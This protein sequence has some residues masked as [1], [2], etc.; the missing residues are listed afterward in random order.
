MFINLVLFCISGNFGRRPLKGLAVDLYPAALEVLG[1]NVT[2]S[3][4]FP[5]NFTR[6]SVN[7]TLNVFVCDN[8]TGKKLFK[9][10]VPLDGRK[11]SVILPCEIFDHPVTYRFKYRISNSD[12]GG[13][14]SQTL[15]L[16]WGGIHIDSPTNHTA[17]T[18]FNSIRIRH[19]RKCLPKSYRDEVNLYYIKGDSKVFVTRKFIRKLSSGKQRIPKMPQ[20]RMGFTCDVFDTQGI[21]YFEYRT[22]YA[23]LTLAKSEAI[24]VYWSQQTLSSPVSTIFPCTNS[25]PI[26]FEQPSCS[27]V[28]SQDALVLGDRYSEKPI[29]QKPVQQGHNVAFFQCSLFND[30]VEEYC[31]HYI[32][33]SR[34]TKST[35]IVASLC[36]PSHPPGTYSG[37]FI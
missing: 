37:D 24:Y 18:R 5:K 8:T 9:T 10:T 15:S 17:L 32:T 23:N 2:L 36:L 4:R 1:G 26:S 28:R 29:V 25:L 31:F 34:L 7:R 20:I 3:F 6:F 11:I 33:K 21:Y 16:Q 22:G 27:F 35:V 19:N 30:Y 12:Y 14:I 13:V